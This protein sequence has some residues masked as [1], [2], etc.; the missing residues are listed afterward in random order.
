M[1]STETNLEQYYFKLTPDFEKTRVD[2]LIV[3]SDI[4]SK[5]IVYGGQKTNTLELISSSDSKS[6]TL[7]RKNKTPEFKPISHNSFDGVAMKITHCDGTAVQFDS[8][9]DKASVLEIC[10]KTVT[11]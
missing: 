7:S 11:Q 5:S 2:K 10:I 3:Y 1:G 4:V 6:E 8:D 9:P